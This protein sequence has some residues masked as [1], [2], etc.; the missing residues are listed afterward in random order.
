MSFDPPNVFFVLGIPLGIVL[1]IDLLKQVCKKNIYKL[2]FSFLSFLC[3]LS[4]LLSIWSVVTTLDQLN[5]NT[6]YSTISAQRTRNI[7]SH[8]NCYG[9][10]SKDYFSFID[11]KKF[12]PKHKNN[13]I[14]NY[15]YILWGCSLL[16][17]LLTMIKLDRCKYAK[18]FNILSLFCCIVISCIQFRL[19]AKNLMERHYAENY[20][21]TIKI[22]EFA[23]NK[24]IKEKP[25]ETKLLLNKKFYLVS[26]HSHEYLKEANNII[27]NLP[28]RVNLIKNNDINTKLCTITKLANWI[29]VILLFVYFILT[30]RKRT[31][32]PT[33]EESDGAATERS[34]GSVS[35]VGPLK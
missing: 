27:K 25:N 24:S 2:K 18:I 10:D 35:G 23:I 8:K 3:F 12:I 17:F 22:L 28:L 11:N 29:F 7:L 19:I 16:I 6:R 30:A 14:G 20:Y 4:F 5:L 31:L 32:Q 13:N 34:A 15:L 26:K 33:S 1:V 21:S 9:I